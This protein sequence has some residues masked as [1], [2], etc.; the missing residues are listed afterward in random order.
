MARPEPAASDRG[1]P[2]G[3]R[4]RSVRYAHHHCAGPRRGWAAVCQLNIYRR[5][6][7]PPKA[8]LQNVIE[9]YNQIVAECET[10]PSLRIVVK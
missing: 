1:G 4:L 10:D 7:T 9:R 5:T 3:A 2:F 6:F 8:T